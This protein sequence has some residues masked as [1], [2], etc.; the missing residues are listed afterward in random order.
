M[1]ANDNA[2]FEAPLEARGKQGKSTQ[3]A[4]SRRRVLGRGAESKLG[5]RAARQS[6]R[7]I[8]DRLSNYNWTDGRTDE[9]QVADD[10]GILTEI[11]FLC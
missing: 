3:R 10:F 9:V 6:W 8:P 5:A 2:P 4:Q 7:K 1:R 11:R